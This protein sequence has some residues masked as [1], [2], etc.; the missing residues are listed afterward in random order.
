MI[1][2]QPVELFWSHA[3]AGLQDRCG[4]IYGPG[5]N[6]PLPEQSKGFFDVVGHLFELDLTILDDDVT[7]ARITIARLSDTAGVYH[8]EASC[9]NLIRDMRMSDTQ[10]IGLDP[11]HSRLPS[12]G[13]GAQIFIHGVARRR[14]QQLKPIPI[15]LHACGN[16]KPGKEFV[17][18]RIDQVPMQRPGRNGQLAKSGVAFRKDPLSDRMVVIPPH[19][20][21]DVLPYPIDTRN[22]IGTVI[23]QIPDEQTRVKRLLNRP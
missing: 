16:R 13:I 2:R 7:C 14:M 15:D 9:L 19:R 4:E 22:G 20:S 3:T 6:A 5:S 10:E 12:S 11:L 1:S 17:A 21:V 18:S 23:D 8:P